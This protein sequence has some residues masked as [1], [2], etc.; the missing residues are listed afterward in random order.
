[1]I[2][3]SSSGES[4]TFR[5]ENYDSITELIDPGILYDAL[6]NI[7]SNILEN[8]IFE[9]EDD[10][11]NEDIRFLKSFSQIHNERRKGKQPR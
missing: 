9:N 1:M 11:D 5:N 8:P 3:H 10:G 6:H 4:K 2:M 7:Y